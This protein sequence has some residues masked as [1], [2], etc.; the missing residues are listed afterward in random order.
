MKTLQTISGL[1]A[2]S[3]GPSTCTLDLLN[4]LYDIHAGVDLLTVSSPDILGAGSLWLKVEPCDYKTPLGL[5]KNIKRALVESEY[6]LYHANALWSYTVHETCK[7]SRQKGKPYILSPHGMLYPTAL[8]IK[9]WKKV[10]MLWWWFNK[11][12]HEATCLHATCQQEAEYIRQFGYK[13][14]IAVIPNAVVFPGYLREVQRV[15]GVRMVQEDKKAFGEKAVLTKTEK[16]ADVSSDSASLSLSEHASEIESALSS[17]VAYSANGVVT[18]TDD[19][20]AKNSKNIFTENSRAIHDN[21]RSEE[22]DS[23][24]TCNSCSKKKTIG[25]LGRLHPIK[26]V[27]NVLYAM[28][29]LRAEG[30]ELRDKL[31]FQIMGKYDDQY[32]QWLKDEVKRLHLEDCVE[33]VG[34]VSGKD[35]YDRLS[36][37][38]ALM[39]PSAQE[40]FGM[41]VPEALICGTP[42]YASLGT[43]WS[44]LNECNAGWWQDNS[45]ATITK[46]ILDILSKSDEELRAMGAN[47]RKL[48]EE[49]YEQHKVAAMMKRLYEWIVDDKMVKDKKP[50]FVY[51]DKKR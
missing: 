19:S 14:P 40:N 6:D 36:K 5:S 28:D 18:N 23:V 31:S 12:I 49:K 11:D 29:K 10:P 43:P 51:L 42:V 21:L 20:S 2:K 9:R 33:F 3:G 48:M 15:Q 35:K 45:P 47:G 16:T 8:A 17:S 25:F 44:E 24:D 37:L 30:L 4:G 46:V 34:F 1:S 26:K 38:S 22:K 13:G 27:E 41:I 39:V 50:E 32:E 7:V